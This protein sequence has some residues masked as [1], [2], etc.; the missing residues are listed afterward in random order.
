MQ[1]R[2][3]GKKLS[4]RTRG[5]SIRLPIEADAHSVVLAGG[6]DASEVWMYARVPKAALLLSFNQL[7]IACLFST[8]T[9]C[10][11]SYCPLLPLLVHQCR[12]WCHRSQRFS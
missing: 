2:D 5:Q 7:V 10:I 6:L 4:S 3:F 1:S 11:A 9:A 8:A 12:S